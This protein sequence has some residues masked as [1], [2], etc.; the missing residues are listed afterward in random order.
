MMTPMIHVRSAAESTAVKTKWNSNPGGQRRSASTIA[1]L[2]AQ[3][4]PGVMPSARSVPGRRRN[5]T[6]NRNGLFAAW[7]LKS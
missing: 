1:A 7:L 6:D 5:A 4:G 2:D 3:T